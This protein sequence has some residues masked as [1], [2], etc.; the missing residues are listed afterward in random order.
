MKP[1]DAQRVYKAHIAFGEDHP[2]WMA[3][4]LKTI[5]EWG[6]AEKTLAHA[7]AEALMEAYD[8]GDPPPEPPQPETHKPKTLIRRKQP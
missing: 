6:R 2:E 4:A 3:W 8:L 1:L 5:N 7:V